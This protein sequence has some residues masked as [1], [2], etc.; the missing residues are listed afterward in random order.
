MRIRVEPPLDRGWITLDPQGIIPNH[1]P[2]NPE[3]LERLRTSM[4]KEGWWGF[5][6]MVEAHA[7]NASHRL[8]VAKELGM[9]EVPC[10]MVPHDYLARKTAFDPTRAE[11]RLNHMR[12]AYGDT[13]PMTIALMVES[14][15]YGGIENF[16]QKA[17]L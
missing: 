10:I 9:K 5:P 11:L 13:H 7:W 3:R 15:Q 1:G 6:V 2:R 4:A 17:G 14:G 12:E 8:A 16:Y